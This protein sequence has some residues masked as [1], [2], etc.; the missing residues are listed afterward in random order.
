MADFNPC[1]HLIP[2]VVDHFA[3]VKGD[4]IYTEFPI[5][6]VNYEEGYRKV[7]WKDL[8]NAVNGVAK[9][10]TEKLG[11]GNGEAL[12]YVGPNDV[13]YPALCLG[14]IKAGY[15]VSFTAKSI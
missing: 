14:A 9:W 12:A 5:S 8:A 11:P 13:R 1:T 7:T 15:C 3:Q 4:E 2:T 10:L 6:P